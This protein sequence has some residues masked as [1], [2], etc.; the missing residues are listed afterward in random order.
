ME[1]AFAAL[2][3]RHGPMVLRV[4]R[5]VLRD[6]HAA[7][8]AFQAT[9]LVLARRAATIRDPA[10]VGCWLH[11]VALRASKT[12]R[13]VEARQRR[14]ERRVA[15]SR[16]IEIEPEDVSD[17][18]VR[19]IL[20]EEI[21]R[22]SP[23]ERG[24][25]LLCDLEG[26]SQREVAERLACP[27]GT[28][29][30]RL[31]GAHRRLRARL[32]QRGLAPAVGGALLSAEARGVV[33]P[34]ALREMTCKAVSS[35]ALRSS[36]AEAGV[37][38]APAADLAS[39]VMTTMTLRNSTK[40]LVLMAG[41]LAV[42]GSVMLSHGFQ[43]APDG[44][45]PSADRLQALEAKLDRL[46]GVLERQ[47]GVPAERYVDFVKPRSVEGYGLGAPS[48]IPGVP[49]D[50]AGPVAVPVPAKTAEPNY[51]P[52]AQ[53]AGAGYVADGRWR[54]AQEGRL[55]HIERQ[56]Q[57]LGMRV[58]RLEQLAA[59]DQAPRDEFGRYGSR[60]PADRAA[61]PSV[62]VPGVPK[63]SGDNIAPGV[64]KESGDDVAR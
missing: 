1:V 18:A 50:P 60:K 47:T 61:L 12:L 49:K 45:P 41:A 58:S 43:Q 28:V 27:V 48:N 10:A 19:V 25:V 20:H 17:P 52:P 38:P 36:A 63:D 31:S 16:G 40:A 54:T 34:W 64:P 6:P 15:A 55:E 62:D 22:L 46:I 30:S 26:L 13:A 5:G 42:S 9:F 35:L 33:L 39:K 23:R 2:V 11:G 8:D 59:G 24:V 3:E 44:A 21:G 56:L 51:A 7:Q 57:E 37:V 32:A 14:H 53:L 4:C 29:K